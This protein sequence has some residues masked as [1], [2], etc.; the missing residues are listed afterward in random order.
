MTFR[1][2]TVLLCALSLTA[3]PAFAQTGAEG[4]FTIV[5]ATGDNTVTGFYTSEDGENFSDN[6]LAEDLAPGTEAQAQFEAASG[7][8]TQ[9]F[10][11]GWLGADGGE[12]QDDVTEI[13]ICQASTVYLGDNEIT[14]E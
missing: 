12:V 9:Y 7:N 3:V 10:V 11:V 1:L 6:W 13:D 5:N 8:C 2:G 14:F 4:H